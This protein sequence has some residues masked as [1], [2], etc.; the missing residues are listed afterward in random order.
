MVAMQARFGV[1][2]FRVFTARL[3]HTLLADAF[4]G[5]ALWGHAARH[6]VWL[7]N[8]I[9]LVRS[10]RPLLQSGATPY[11]A[12]TGD[13]PD[14]SLA[15]APFG[16]TVYDKIVGTKPSHLR[17]VSRPC[18]W[19]GVSDDTVGWLVLD[20]NN[21]RTRY[22]YH[23]GVVW[24]LRYHPA[25]LARSDHLMRTPGTATAQDH[26][27]Q[28]IRRLFA[29]D[30]TTPRDGIMVIDDLTRA[31]L[32]LVPTVGEDD[33]IRLEPA[34]PSL[35]LAG[36]RAPLS[37]VHREASEPSGGS[38]PQTSKPMDVQPAA[39]P[40]EAA[41]LP[42]TGTASAEL[43][44]VHD[45]AKRRISALFWK[46]DKYD[47]AP[48]RWRQDNPKRPGTASHKRYATYSQTTTLGG[49]KRANGTLK[50]LQWDYQRGFVSLPIDTQLALLDPSTAAVVM[51]HTGWRA[52]GQYTRGTSPH[53]GDGMPDDKGVQAGDANSTSNAANEGRAPRAAVDDA[54]SRLAADV[55]LARGVAVV[56][57]MRG[58]EHARLR[59]LDEF[60]HDAAECIDHAL[61]VTAND[62][63]RPDHDA[64]L[65]GEP[66]FDATVGGGPTTPLDCPAPESPGQPIAN[67]SDSE[68][69]D[70][71][72]EEH[73]RRR[74]VRRRAGTPRSAWSAA[75]SG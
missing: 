17:D 3:R 68:P 45:D 20:L 22:T 34:A 33:E 37:E 52:M 47:R 39:Q 70:S 54:H 44:E 72:L 6:A 43:E 1:S 73:A 48:L 40:S 28:A 9:S 58:G 75:A 27:R 8:R 26:H 29:P 35:P 66:S 50:D 59:S 36:G 19:M 64:R 2:F 18:L 62:H 15:I 41:P 71:M 53:G 5:D 65:P 42:G 63:A 16:A 4:L 56:D 60:V 67:T 74:S 55:P 61:A 13:K 46:T 32:W 69:L 11:Q 24:D 14:L 12:W 57:L 21:L 30:P 38:Q 7:T 49:Y 25:Q 10:G 31:P 23:I 51:E